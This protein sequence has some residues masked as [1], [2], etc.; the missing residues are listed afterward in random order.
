M[1]GPRGEE[2]LEPL[3]LVSV[4]CFKGARVVGVYFGWV[5]GLRVAAGVDSVAGGAGGEER[6]LG[7][8]VV[9]GHGGI[10]GGLLFISWVKGRRP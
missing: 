6:L 8:V 4:P 2:A 9:G 1:L 3:E 5:C 7:T 10:Y